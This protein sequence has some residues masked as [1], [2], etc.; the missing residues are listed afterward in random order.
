MPDQKVHHFSL[1]NREEFNLKGVTK[2]ETFDES[3]III[4]TNAGPLAIRGDNLHINHLNLESGDLVVFGLVKLIQY[5]DPQGLKSAK[6]KGKSI[7]N[8]LLK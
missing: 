6:G 2:V 1:A 4:E 3:E 7:I 8:R 5:L